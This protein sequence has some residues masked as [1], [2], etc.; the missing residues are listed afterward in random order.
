M[1]AGDTDDAQATQKRKLSQSL[2]HRITGRAHFMRARL[3][4]IT[5]WNRSSAWLTR[6]SEV[7]LHISGYADLAERSVYLLTIT[8]Q[9]AKGQC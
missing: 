3:D 6:T 1:L 8:L 5:A 9:E 7:L 2:L 4:Y